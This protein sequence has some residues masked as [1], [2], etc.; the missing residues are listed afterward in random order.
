MTLYE[1]TL[2]AVPGLS[3]FVTVEFV[4]SKYIEVKNVY[5]IYT[6]VTN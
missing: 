1:T 6:A 5:S 2:T 3:S 4:A